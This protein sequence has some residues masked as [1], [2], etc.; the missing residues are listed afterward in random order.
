MTKAKPKN[1]QTRLR[2]IF[3]RDNLPRSR[4]ARISIGVVMVLLGVVGCLPS[5]GFWIDIPVV[6]KFTRKA[7]VVILRWWKKL[8]AWWKKLRS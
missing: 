8:R 6:R 5:L 3:S 1:L 4:V 7:T 2:R